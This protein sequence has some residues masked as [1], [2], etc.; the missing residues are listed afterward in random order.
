MH[1][2]LCRRRL[3]IIYYSVSRRYSSAV[4]TGWLVYNSRLS[5]SNTPALH[6]RSERIFC[7]R[8]RLVTNIRTYVLSGLGSGIPSVFSIVCSLISR[9]LKSP[10][11]STTLILCLGR[12]A[13]NTFSL[14][15]RELLSVLQLYGSAFVSPEWYQSHFAKRGYI[16]EP[17]VGW[18]GVSPDSGSLI[19]SPGPA[20][21]NLRPI[22]GQPPRAGVLS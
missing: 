11:R 12:S 21:N 18:S 20:L 8:T 2:L 22:S 10:E 13:V 5:S 16:S 3:T 7:W 9:S 19:S 17:G 15:S 14:R 1:F 6:V 4:V